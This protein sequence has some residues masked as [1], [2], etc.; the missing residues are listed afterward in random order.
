MSVHVKRQPGGETT[1]ALSGALTFLAERQRPN[2]ELATEISAD[3][4]MLADCVEDG[5]VFTT[6]IVAYSLS[7]LNHPLAAQVQN[8]ALDFLESEEIPPGIWRYWTFTSG[9]AI[10]ADV[11]DTAF[12]SFVLQLCGR[13]AQLL[14]ANRRILLANRNQNG[15]FR[16]WIH[17]GSLNDVDSVANANVLLYLGD[18][19]ETGLLSK[20]LND[21]IKRDAVAG[22]IY[23]YTTERALD[24]A[25]CRA[26]RHNRTSLLPA[27]NQLQARLL[28]SRLPD[29]SFG[30]ELETALAISSFFNLA[31]VTKVEPPLP[32][33]RPAIDFLLRR[34]QPDGG[35]A[36]LA[37]YQ[38]PAPPSPPS[39]YFGSRELTTG[40]CLEAIAHYVAIEGAGAPD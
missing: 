13:G 3:P 25:M 5:A 7:W 30:N 1:R 33:L 32:F 22:T 19:T 31:T 9:K 26:L 12:I 2:G 11:D 35:W 38:G 39:Y 17:S 21:L 6:S 24:Y 4:Q 18:E 8:R 20:F 23:Y 29:G 27:A 37:Y 10:A 15:L 40:V 14:A 34:Q 36:R 16:T 28:R